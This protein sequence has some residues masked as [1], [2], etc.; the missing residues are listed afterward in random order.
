MFTP[1]IEKLLFNPDH[2]TRLILPHEIFM[3]KEKLGSFAT[4]QMRNADLK[5]EA[6]EQSSE[7][8]HDNAPMDAANSAQV[9]LNSRVQPFLHLWMNHLVVDYVPQDTPA[10]WLGSRARISMGTDEFSVDIV[11]MQGLYVPRGIDDPEVVSYFAPLGQSLL[12]L[13]VGDV[14]SYAVRG[15]LLEVTV[16]DI[17]QLAIQE[18]FKELE[19]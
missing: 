19:I 15:S 14:G 13:K 5:R 16:L 10:V 12:S 11:G 8:W 9:A 18:D 7:T 17:D 4:E 6:M 2:K 1:E 3:L